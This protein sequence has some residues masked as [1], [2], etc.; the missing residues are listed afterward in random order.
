MVIFFKHTAGKSKFGIYYLN[1]VIENYN[2]IIIV[3]QNNMKM[4]KA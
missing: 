3:Y 1:Q 4:K 2:T